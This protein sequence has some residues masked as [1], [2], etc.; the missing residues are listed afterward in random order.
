MLATSLAL[1]MDVLRAAS[2]AASVDQR[3]RQPINFRFAA[4][5]TETVSSVGGL[6]LSPDLTL[7][8]I[9]H[10]D[11]LLLPAMWRNPLPVLRQQREWLPLLRQSASA[12]HPDLQRR[13]GQLLH[14][15]GGP[16]G[17]PGRHHALELFQ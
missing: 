16:A 6:K 10:C 2:Q 11:L 7:E 14:G 1:P 3:A 8:E 12:G 9:D 5:T 4:Q 13:H 15:R 17:R